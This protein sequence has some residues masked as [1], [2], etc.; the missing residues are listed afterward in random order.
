MLIPLEFEIIYFNNYELVGK[1][2]G[3]F[4]TI[5]IKMEYTL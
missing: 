1:D 3:A 2:G 4:G 5:M